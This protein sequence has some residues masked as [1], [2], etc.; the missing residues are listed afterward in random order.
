MNVVRDNTRLTATT[1]KDATK[2]AIIVSVAH[3]R[4]VSTYVKQVRWKKVYLLVDPPIMK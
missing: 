4:Y 1:E 2:P 3:Y